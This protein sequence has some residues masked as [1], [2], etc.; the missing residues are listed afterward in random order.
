MTGNIT[1]AENTYGKTLYQYDKGGHLV[2]QKDVTTGEE[3]RFEYD[4]AGN[5]TRLY[6][7]NRET[8]YLYG[9]NNEVTEI[10][11][12]KQRLSVKLEYNVNGLETVRR[13]GNGTKEET[14]YDKAGCVTV[15]LQKN[16]RN[17]L[18]W[19]EGYVYGDDGKR[20]ATVD[21]KG[22]VTLYEYNKKGQIQNVYYPY[23]QEI[24]NNLRKEAEENGLPTNTDISENRYLPADI[25][26]GLIPLLNSMQYGLAY[27]LPN[28]QIFVKESYS[29]DKNGNRTGKTTKYGTI[30]YSYDKENRLVSSGSRGQAFINYTYDNAGN[31]LTEESAIKS[32]KYAYNAQNRLIYCEVTDKAEKTYA[33]TTYAYDAF[34]RRVIVQDKG[35]AAVRT[36]YDGFTFDV[37]K[38][39]STL[40][41]GLFTDS[42]NTG[43]RWSPTG[44]PT[45]DRYRYIS[46]EDAQDDNRY[47]Y[48]DENIYKTVNSRYRGER[49]Q[50]SVNGSLAAQT[51]NEGAQ[52]FTTDLFGSVSTVSDSLGY[53][54]DSYS[55]DAFGSLVQG[56]LSGSTDFGY[57]GKQNDPSSKLY[58]YGYRDYKPEAARFTTVDPIRDGTNWFAYVNNDPVNHIDLWGLC[59]GSDKTATS[60]R[61]LSGLSNI[62]YGA[63]YDQIMID[64]YGMDL[65]N[66]VSDEFLATHNFQSRFENMVFN[67]D[68]PLNQLVLDKALGLRTTASNTQSCQ[69][70]A[71]LNA[72]AVN[73][74]N[75]I[76]GK[77]ISN[78]LKKNSD[79]TFGEGGF[80]GDDGRLKSIWGLGYYMGKELGTKQYITSGD[81]KII[82]PNILVN[83]NVGAIVGLQRNENVRDDHYVYRDW[84][85]TIDSMNHTRPVAAEYTDYSCRPL[86]WADY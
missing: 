58:N 76:T 17:E 85:V 77:N 4:G 25:K 9:K 29:Y 56:D 43:I 21:N 28:M 11:D 27:S 36:L 18:L 59:E 38:Q 39:S 80:V 12:N 42:N 3:I 40:A 41:N 20:T 16:E 61:V 49:T 51:T 7:S 22:L 66:G 65:S 78:V 75:G 73:T 71:V 44:K 30:N 34:G 68:N 31:L 60:K 23:S 69:T 8:K 45:G 57:L 79:G 19:A 24:I 32:T 47:F 72:W 53:Q 14:L 84:S 82:P 5:R 1:E 86:Y 10:F 52:Y 26:S 81:D 6:S 50:I 83:M 46:D 67:K 64:I 35:E 33:Q 55:Y 15:K 37:I 62:D 13:F 63:N 48:L 54:L 2:Y 70:T 74:E